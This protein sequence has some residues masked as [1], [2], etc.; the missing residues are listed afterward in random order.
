MITIKDIAEKTGLSSASVSRIL[1]HDPTLK[2]PEAT[3]NRVL[4]EAKNLGYI[5]RKFNR[6]N[7]YKPLRIG[8]VQWYSMERELRDPF[9]LGIR[10]GTENALN[11]NNVEIVRFFK[12]DGQ[13]LDLNSLDALICIGK[14]SKEE[15]AEFRKT[16]E[17]LIF[18]DMDMERIYVNTICLDFKNAVIDIMNHLVGLGHRKIGFLGGIESTSDNEEYIDKRRQ[19]FEDYCN[20]NSISY[21]RFIKQAE[22]TLE[23]GYAMM[24]E[25]ITSGELPTAIFAASDPIALGAMRAL[26]EYNLIIPH[27]ISIIAFNNDPSS[28]FSNPPLT[29][30]NAPSEKMGEI[31]AMTLLEM[32]SLKKVYPRKIVIPCELVIRE[33]C[34]PRK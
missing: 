4:E 8:I 5:K 22:F 27:D 29:T 33:S 15:I 14:F 12:N 32:R 26:S 6:R 21:K 34:G 13:K 30:V 16:T 23:S 1:N 28:A 9:Y 2:V 18:V 3:R 31:A 7:N 10:I 25:M 19:Y 24:K 11:K 17:H 20:Q